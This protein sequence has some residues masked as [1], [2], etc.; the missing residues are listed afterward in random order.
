MYNRQIM[1]LGPAWLLICLTLF[2]VVVSADP[3]NNKY[4]HE[5]AEDDLH[6]HYDSRFYKR[7]VSDEERRV[8]LTAL[9]RAYLL[10][11]EK[12]NLETWIG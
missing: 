5:P 2:I 8:T 3:K 1:K 7:I 9:I 6:R 11:F 12:F 10:L 4:F